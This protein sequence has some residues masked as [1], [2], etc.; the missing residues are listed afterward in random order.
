M[1]RVGRKIIIVILLILIFIYTNRLIKIQSMEVINTQNFT[2]YFQG[3][4][5]ENGGLE[6]V[7]DNFF[8]FKKEYIFTSNIETDEKE[9]KVEKI[10]YKVVQGDTLAS[11]AKKN[12]VSIDTIKANN[13]S[14]K[15]SKLKVGDEIEFPSLDG[16]FYEIKKGDSF[17]SISKK[18]GIKLVDIVN[19]N[20]VDPKRLRPGSEIFLKD[21]TYKKIQELENL[22]KKAEKEKKEKELAKKKAA[23][24]KAKK[25]VKKGIAEVEDVPS[26]TSS[27]QGGSGFSFPVKYAGVNSPF[28]NRF[29][30]VLKRYV[31]HTGV[32]LEAKYVPLR[33]ARSGVV[34]FAGNMNGYGKIII[35]KHS[36]GYE[37]RYAHLSVISTKVG[38]NVKKGELIGKTGKSGRVTGPHLHFEIRKNGVPKD[39]MKYLNK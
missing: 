5:S 6:L 28:G 36:D 3:S 35:I 8:T 32:D 39:P 21:V 17:L 16:F 7:V 14:G 34:T 27:I 23:E 10:K 2:D 37:T 26:D 15:L 24:E 19:F 12:N 29:H 4:E 11:I 38:E 33:A 13:D 9:K 22:R 25:I 31:L 1:K 30:P 18:Y 20:D